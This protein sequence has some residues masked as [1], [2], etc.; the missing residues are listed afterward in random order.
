MIRSSHC[1]SSSSWTRISRLSRRAKP[2]VGGAALAIVS[3]TAPLQSLLED[4]SLFIKNWSAGRQR[5]YSTTPTLLKS[6]SSAFRDDVDDSATQLERTVEEQYSRKTPLEHVLLRPGMYVGP[7]ERLPPNTCWILDPLPDPDAPEM[8]FRMIRK[9]Y[10]LVPALIKIFD[11]IL[12]NASDNRLRHPKSCSRIDVEIDPGSA[13]EG[14]AP[15]ISVLNDGKGIPVQ[16]HSK[17]KLYVPEMLFGHLLTGSNFDD[18][19][20]RVTGGRHGYG[21]KLTNIFSQTFTVETVDSRKRKMYKQTWHDNMS[22]STEPEISP[23]QA[24]T[25]DYTRISFVPDMARLTGRPDAVAIEK[26]DYAVMC[27]RVVDV[28]GCA[29]GHLTVTLNGK[30]V[31]LASFEEYSNMYRHSDAPPLVYQKINSRWEVGVGLSDSGSFDSVSFVNGMA[32]PRGGTHINAIV[33]QITSVVD[34]RVAKLYP[35]LADT[36]TPGMIR[37]NLFVS[38]NALIENPTFD[39]QMKESLTSNPNSFGSSCDLPKKFLAELVSDQ[40]DGGPGIVEEIARVARGRQQANLLKQVGGANKSR[41][42]LLSIPKLDDAHLAGSDQSSSCSLILTEGDSAKALAVAGLEVI[43]RERYGVFPLRGKFL[44]VRHASVDQLMNNAEVK[45]LCSIIGLDFDKEYDTFAERSELRYGHCLLMTDQDADGSHIKGLVMNFFRHFWPKLLKPAVDQP[46]DKPFL[47]SFVTPLLKATRKGKKEAL[48]FYSM[49]DYNSWRASMS[50]DDAKK[51]TVKYY[52]GLG[53]STPAEAKEYFSAFADHHRPFHWNS[54]LDGELLDMVFDKE[55]AADRRQWILDEFDDEATITPDPE[56]DNSVTFEDFV[57]NEMIHFSNADN[58][59]SLPSV[60]DG[61][62][63]S[64]RKVL[65]ACFKRKLKSEIKVAQLTGYCAE[66]TAYHHGEAS[67]HSTSK[68]SSPMLALSHCT[69]PFV[70]HT[71]IVARLCSYWHGSGLCGLEQHQ[72]AGAFRPVW[73]TPHRR[74]GRS[75]AALHFHVSFANCK[76]AL[77]GSRRRLAHAQRR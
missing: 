29:A 2:R 71:F 64:Q 28:A 38:C 13:E 74:Q 59:R 9:E 34:A 25:K 11:E 35:E 40:E 17:E 24:G 62:K 50:K 10:G 8:P 27:R 77:P 18:N 41:R 46:L 53:T 65:Y 3:P 32:T 67:L 45:A 70:F 54:E 6:S 36:V 19:E 42:Q 47:S 31:S 4:K 56:R 30:D 49:A 69:P 15:F 72:F 5:F 21:A 51:W 48:A 22:V 44:N 23:V 57:N 73:Y 12:V 20:R 39:S 16:E 61:L 26:E 55:R 43:G 52:K 76:T 33:Q 58:I 68:L 37:R 1:R 63:P 75:F 7:N 14:R 66:H 60:V